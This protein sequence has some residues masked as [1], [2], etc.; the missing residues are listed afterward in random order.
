MGFIFAIITSLFFT[1]YTIP[2][3]LSRQSTMRYS[4]FQG[5]GFFGA[6]AIVYLIHCIIRSGDAEPLNDPYLLLSALSGVFWFMGCAFFFMAIDEMGLSRSNQ[7]KNLQGPFGAIFNLLF[8]AEYKQTNVL[9]ILLSCGAI[10]VS[11]IFLTIKGNEQKAFSRRG[12]IYALLAAVLF[13]LNSMLLKNGT[14]HGFIYSQQIVLSGAVFISSM[15][16]LLIKEKSI[17]CIRE[18]SSKDNL[19]GILGG[20]LFY[21]ASFFSLHSYN[22]LPGSITFTII[23]LNAVWTVLVGVFIFREIEFRKNWLRIALGMFFAVIGV[24]LL[25]FA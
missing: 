14:N 6:S 22:L 17:S 10:L 4:M 11:A 19:L 24:I 2:K 7:W 23:Q 13:G 5:M 16:F 12:I 1:A 15:V 21:A 18:L 20:V 3:K 8:L 25:L 9:F